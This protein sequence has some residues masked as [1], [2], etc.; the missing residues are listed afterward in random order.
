MTSIWAIP[1]DLAPGDRSVAGQDWSGYRVHRV[2]SP[3]DPLFDPAL[4]ALASD[5]RMKQKSPPRHIIERRLFWTGMNASHGCVKRYRL[6]VMMC[7]TDFAAARDHIA[8]ALTGEP[9]VVVCLSRKVVASPFA[10]VGLD[11]WLRALPLQTARSLMAAQGR[12]F[13]EP[14]TLVDEVD[15]SVPS[16]HRLLQ[17]YE[18]AGFSSIDPV[19]APYLHPC[20]HPGEEQGIPCR[21]IVR[22]VGHESESSIPGDEL[23]RLGHT[24]LAMYRSTGQPS[25]IDSLE[26]RLTRWPSGSDAVALLPPT[27]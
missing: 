11:A 24:L 6:I 25:D 19:A 13:D 7:G 3:E 14:I 27:S 22:R 21:L 9:G 26:A 4:G 5:P 16:H 10:D 2:V 15:A 1:R 12:D 17:Q 8:A 20:S 23:R 18:A